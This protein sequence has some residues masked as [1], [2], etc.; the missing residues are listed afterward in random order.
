MSGRLL[1]CALYG[2]LCLASVP[3]L[4]EFKDPL[5]TPALMNVELAKSSRM[6]AITRAGNRL[7]AVGAIGHIVLSD[8]LGRSWQQVPVPTSVDLV[9]VEFFNE[10]LGW[11]VGHDGVV[12]HSQDGGQSWSKQLDGNRVIELYKQ[13]DETLA[14]RSDEEAQALRDELARYIGEGPDKPFLDVLF[15][16][17]HEGFV[18]G[19]FNLAFH[20]V[21]GGQ[22]WTPLTGRTDNPRSL[23]LYALA[24]SGNDLYAAGEQGLLLR[25][26]AVQLRFIALN[27]PYHGS[28]FGLL[29]T[30]HELV[31]YGL[32]GNAFVSKDRG[33]SWSELD[34]G[35]N[36]SI[37]GASQ[38]PDGRMVLVSQVGKLLVGT[39]AAALQELTPRRAMAYFDVSAAGN[40][41]VVVVGS[42]GVQL[43]PVA[44]QN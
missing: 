14:Q 37:T 7:V 3:V 6:T 5:D 38:L 9:A 15:I 24:R 21:D 31:A 26:D 4:G 33:E 32:R 20:T 23:H 39:S 28:F 30:D 27:S 2:A 13:L 19:A 16:S 8:D 42:T 25:W 41:A 36:D 22:T 29:G 10:Q 44:G 34:T 1:K 18:V 12:L 43:E 40:G 17:E 35:S 11:A